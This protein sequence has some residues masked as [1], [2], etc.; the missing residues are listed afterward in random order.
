MIMEYKHRVQKWNGKYFEEAWSSSTSYYSMG[1][2][3]EGGDDTDDTEVETLGDL[4]KLWQEGKR[5]D[6]ACCEK[7]WKYRFY[8][9]TVQEED[10]KSGGTN[11]V[12]YV[13][14]G[15][16]YR[17]GSKVFFKPIGQ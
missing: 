10:N 12:D 1:A 11:F 3:L 17:R 13:T 8:K 16:M 2:Y 6:A 5:G 9:H 7:G 4:Y 14:E 15:K